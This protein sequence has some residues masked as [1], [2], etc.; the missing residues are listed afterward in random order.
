[1]RRLG[2]AG[3]L[4]AQGLNHEGHERR[5]LRYIALVGLLLVPVALMMMSGLPRR[6]VAGPG[7]EQQARGSLTPS[8]PSSW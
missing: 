2:R 3:L 6:T 1:M 4:H 5:H 7:A 8:A